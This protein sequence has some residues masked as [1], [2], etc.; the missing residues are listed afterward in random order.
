MRAVFDRSP[1]DLTT[2]LMWT[3]VIATAYLLA[4]LAGLELALVRGQVS[5]IWPASGIGLFFLL[6]IGL[7]TVPGI[8]IGALLVNVTLGPTVL[9]VAM[10]MLGNTL[11]PVTAYLLLKWVGFRPNLNRLVDA[12][13]LVGLGGFAGMLVS[14]TLGTSA[15]T[16]A[17][18]LPEEGFWGTWS[19][20]WTGD[21][22]GV[23]IIGPVLLLTYADRPV[24]LRSPLRWAEGIGVLG[25]ATAIASW[26]SSSDMAV[27]F[28]MFLPLI[29]AAVRFQQ[30]GAAPCALAISITTTLAAADMTGPFSG[31][32]L[33]STMTILQGFNGSTA[34]IALLLSSIINQRNHAQAAVEETCRVLADAVNRLGGAGALGE[35][36]LAAVRRATEGSIAR[37]GK[38]AGTEDQPAV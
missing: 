32:D 31:L 5:P 33:V 13:A 37:N 38:K 29:W 20:W 28:S 8:A 4:G 36:T 16:V 27:L 34:L 23:L 7:K 24:W 10:I 6:R 2:W 15:L 17:D 18:A 12:L 9:A 35:R 3:A 22:M 14:A 1:K 21:A 30:I 26:A 25:A 11:A 19:V